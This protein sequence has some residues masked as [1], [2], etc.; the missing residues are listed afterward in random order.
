MSSPRNPPGFH[1]PGD[2]K[3]GSIFGAGGT[4]ERSRTHNQEAAETGT[5]APP[6]AF[7]ESAERGRDFA[8]G[9]KKS[10]GALATAF[11]Q[12]LRSSRVS[13]SASFG[14][15]LTAFARRDGSFFVLFT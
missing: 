1:S 11:R 7:S 2:A 6:L 13:N 15:S 14:R 4:P 5:L 8:V 9:C 10:E 12:A 3:T